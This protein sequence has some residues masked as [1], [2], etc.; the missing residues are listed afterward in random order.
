MP[1]PSGLVP[2]ETLVFRWPLTPS[3]YLLIFYLVSF[4][5]R[6]REEERERNINEREKC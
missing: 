3:V 4:R 1:V 6:G 5:G 2:E